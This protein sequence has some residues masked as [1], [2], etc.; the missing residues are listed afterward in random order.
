MEV[1]RGGQ[2][3][4]APRVFTYRPEVSVRELVGGEVDQG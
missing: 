1:V 2:S 3:L 4:A